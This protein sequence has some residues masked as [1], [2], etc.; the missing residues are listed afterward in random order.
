MTVTISNHASTVAKDSGKRLLT[1]LATPPLTTSGAR[2]LRRVR[3]AA[4]V[5]GSSSAIVA[6]LLE[7]ATV[8]VRD[9]AIAGRD[10]DEWHNS[11]GLLQ[12][13]IASADYVLLAW[14]C[15]EPTGPA[16]HHHRA[17]V[18]WV[19]GELNTRGLPLWTFGGLPRHPSR[20][21]RYT[22]REHPGSTFRAAVAVSLRQK[23][24]HQVPAQLNSSTRT[25]GA[26]HLDQSPKHEEISDS[27]SRSAEFFHE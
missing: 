20:W 11:R 18:A 7:V 26:S 17:Q 12:A 10:S 15:S 8:D 2:T 19:M 5:I 13:A 27:Y 14:G 4:E 9:I 23:E 22:S 1:I 25:N 16:K 3:M 6:N 24:G 21:Q